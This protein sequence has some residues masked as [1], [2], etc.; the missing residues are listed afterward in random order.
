MSES[1]IS[2]WPALKK[3]KIKNHSAQE[4]ILADLS[5]LW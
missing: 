5:I 3:V 2:N 4:Q 1:A